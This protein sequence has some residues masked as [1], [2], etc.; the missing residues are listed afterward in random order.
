MTDNITLPRPE[1]TGAF[2]VA[3]LYHFARFPRFESVRE[4]LFRLC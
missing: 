3:A 1:A 2:L 4:P